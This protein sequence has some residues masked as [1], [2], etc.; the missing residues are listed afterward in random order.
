[1]S[2]ENQYTYDRRT[3]TKIVDKAIEFGIPV[4]TVEVLYHRAVSESVGFIST[5]ERAKYF[6]E[7]ER[8]FLCLLWAYA[9][10]MPLND[11]D[12][13][14]RIIGLHRDENISRLVDI[15]LRGKHGD[16]R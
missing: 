14:Q 3:A 7:R 8:I 15:T 2:G 6:R 16:E 13:I 5:G 4:P 1:M 9:K 10:K 11:R 12:D